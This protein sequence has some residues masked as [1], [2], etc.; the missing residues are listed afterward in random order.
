VDGSLYRLLVNGEEKVRFADDTFSNGGFMLQV[1]E[2][3]AE[4]EA[5]EV[6]EMP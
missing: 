3:Y 2:G 4:I 1:P 5:V 6:T